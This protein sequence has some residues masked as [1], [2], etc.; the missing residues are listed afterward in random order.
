MRRA[1]KVDDNQRQIVAA[2]RAIGASVQVLSMVGQGCPD[3]LCAYRGVN[4]LLELKDGAKTASRRKLTLDE[5]RWIMEWNAPVHIVS[6][7]SEAYEAIGATVE[8]L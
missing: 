7:V 2:L 4:H 8:G 1:A 3:I 6:S 5:V